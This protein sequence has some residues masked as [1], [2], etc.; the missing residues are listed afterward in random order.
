MD[1]AIQ[2]IHEASLSL[3]ENPGIRLEHPAICE[4]FLARGAKTGAMADVVRIPR[5]L[6][7]EIIALAP[8]EIALN[9]RL[10]TATQI[11]TPAGGTAIWS[12]PGMNWYRRGELRPFTSENMAAHARLLD[13]LPQVDGVFGVAM[14]DVPPAV[15]DVAGLSIMAQNTAKHI[16]VLCFTPRGGEFLRNAAPLYPGNWLSMGFTSHGPLRWTHLALEMFAASAGAGIPV[17]VNGEP[18]AG[19]SGPVTVAG[20]AAVGNAEILAGIAV[21]QLLEPGRPCIYNLGLAHLFDMRTA[22][23]ITGGPESHIFADLSARL[24]R[25][26]NLPSCSWVS[27]ESLTPDAQ[28]GY[29]KALGFQTHLASRVSLVWGVGQLE[30]ATTISPAQAVIDNEILASVRRIARGAEI[31][32]ETIALETIR[33]V[34]ICGDFLGTDHTLDNFR[35]AIWQ[36]DISFRAKRARWLETGA[37]DLAAVAEDRADALIAATAEKAAACREATRDLAALADE[38][39]KTG[40]R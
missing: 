14:K 25:F 38:F 3:L 9:G 6:L 33:E 32:E 22:C 34:G 26:Y 15:G 21:N 4:K 27:T 1:N 20:S 39:M 7:M 40:W 36:P 2:Q 29:E 37:K 16:R 35:T 5:E 12:C 19:T 30:S 8:S 18:M 11:L 23:V 13:A 28:A 17:T 31:S 10:G 24:G